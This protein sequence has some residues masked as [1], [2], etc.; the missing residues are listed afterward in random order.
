MC[1]RR[2]GIWTPQPLP[3]L[4]LWSLIML[5]GSP[6]PQLIE[7]KHSHYVSSQSNVSLLRETW[8]YIGRWI[9]CS[10]TQAI[11]SYISFLYILYMS[12]AVGSGMFFGIKLMFCSS[13]VFLIMNNC[14]KGGLVINLFDLTPEPFSDW[15]SLCMRYSDFPIGAC[16]EF[17][18]LPPGSCLV[19]NAGLVGSVLGGLVE[20]IDQPETVAT[21]GLGQDWFCNIPPPPT[22]GHWLPG[23]DLCVGSTNSEQFVPIPPPIILRFTG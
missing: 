12:F 16:L 22:T 19:I 20:E 10:A 6:I 18:Y 17:F 11:G 21:R 7:Q 13:D 15:A 8:L 3:L 23:I 14:A 9:S 4:Q 5:I 2:A 1:N